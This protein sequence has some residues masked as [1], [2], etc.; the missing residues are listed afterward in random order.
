MFFKMTC[1]QE[2][3]DDIIKGNNLENMKIGEIGMYN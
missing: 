1:K 2:L 3:D